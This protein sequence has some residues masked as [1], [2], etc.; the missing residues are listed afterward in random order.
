MPKGADAAR[1]SLELGHDSGKVTSN[2]LMF[3]GLFQPSMDTF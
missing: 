3:D 2:V 1:A